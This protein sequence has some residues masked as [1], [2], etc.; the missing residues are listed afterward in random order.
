MVTVRVTVLSR[1]SPSHSPNRCPSHRDSPSHQ[2]ESESSHPTRTVRVTG[3]SPSRAAG[4]TA[5]RASSSKSPPKP[6]PPQ[7]PQTRSAIGPFP[8]RPRQGPTGHAPTAGRGPSDLEE[9]RS[10]EA[11]VLRVPAPQASPGPVLRRRTVAAGRRPPPTRCQGR[12]DERR[13]ALP[14]RAIPASPDPASLTPEQSVRT[15]RPLF[16]HYLTR[17]RQVLTWVID[18]HPSYAARHRWTFRSGSAR[19]AGWLLRFV[20]GPQTRMAVT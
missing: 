7:T 20:A 8:A 14:G 17:I 18:A 4:H 2:S 11:R 19:P 13:T 6:P 12:L 10:E 5:T 1:R 15:L 9:A 3:R 16:D